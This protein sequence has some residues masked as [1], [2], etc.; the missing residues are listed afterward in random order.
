MGLC[1]N[2]SREEGNFQKVGLSSVKRRKMTD[3][4]E[5]NEGI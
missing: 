3:E 2:A 5:S 1:T 4:R